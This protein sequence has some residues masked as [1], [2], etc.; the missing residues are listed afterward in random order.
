MA[1]FLGI[2]N[3]PTL[4]L[5]KK[6]AKVARFVQA[7]STL[8]V[9]IPCHFLKN[10]AKWQGIRKKVTKKPCHFFKNSARWQG[11]RKKVTKKPC[12]FNV[13]IKMWQGQ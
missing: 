2:K 9:I 4:P 7:F 1:R 6:F 13:K 5:V 10:S 3:P 11:I 8:N 12:H